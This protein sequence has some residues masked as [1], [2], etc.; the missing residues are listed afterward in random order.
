MILFTVFMTHFFEKGEMAPHST[1]GD[2]QG[3]SVITMTGH[4][5]RRC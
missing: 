2:L 5:A 4:V 1:V 3:L